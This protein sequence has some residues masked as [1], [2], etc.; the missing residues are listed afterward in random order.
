MARISITKTDLELAWHRL[1]LDRPDRCFYTPPFILSW[2]SPNIPSW[3]NSISKTISQ[4]YMP[5]DS[6]KCYVP[7]GGWL[8]RP[9][10]VLTLEDE[11]VYNA[12][13]GKEFSK[14][15]SKLKWS[16]GD[17]DI[18]YQLQGGSR[19]K[20]WIRSGFLV[21]REWRQRSI[22][23]LKS[24]ISQVVFT[25][26]SGFYDNIDLNILRS[27][28]NSIGF[29]P[30]L[31][32]LLMNCLNRWSNP[33]GRG[34]PQ[35][36][37][38]SDILAK[39][40]LNQI[41]NA[42]RNA[43]YK[44]LHYVDDFRIFC[45]SILEAKKSISYLTELLRNRGLNLQAAKTKIL[46][47]ERAIQKIDG[48]APVIDEI[49][50]ELR[51]ELTEIGGYS[52]YATLE[53]LNSIIESNPEAPAPEILERAFEDRFLI[54]DEDVFDT[55]LFHYLLT[56]LE[57]INSRIAVAYCLDLLRRRPEETEVILRYFSGIKIKRDEILAI[58][59]YCE[60]SDAIYDY[61]LFQ[62]VKWFYERQNFPKR[63]IKLCRKWYFDRNKAIWLRSYCLAVIGVGGISAD[64]EIIENS[65][66][67]ATN[68][69]EKA[70]IITALTRMEIG[71]RNSFYGRVKGDGELVSWAIQ[72]VRGTK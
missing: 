62:I 22:R 30:L 5:H 45:K 52:S 54:S 60:S 28:L 68:E 71:R 13:L 26:I 48:I 18:A 49:Q 43:G 37:S 57:K 6:F 34:I 1:K 36:Y 3:L 67:S 55:T 14:I 53:Y 23:K 32:E 19:N 72:C 38:G 15:H 50:N 25:D 70:E 59:K 65:Y 69:L 40:Y 41:N 4:G 39:V 21:W 31:L 2:I 24:D 12:I 10:S 58:I 61:Q 66:G 29:D 11:I 8:V 56:R 9:G 51:K 16:Q 63:L 44:H 35:G 17:P 33:K 7:K 64:L 42:L 47:K 46:P 27:D 20:K